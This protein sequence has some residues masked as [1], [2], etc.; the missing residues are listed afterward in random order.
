MAR[1]RAK[2]VEMKLRRRYLTFSLR[3]LFVVTTA[4]A[5]WLG[6]IVNRAREQREAVKAIEALGGSASYDWQY[7][8]LDQADPFGLDGPFIPPGPVWLRRLVGDDFFQDAVGVSFSGETDALKSIAHLKR[9]RKLKTVIV[10]P[11]AS[12]VTTDEIKAALPN[13]E[14]NVILF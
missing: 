7:A 6:V 4:L 1:F 11:F 9:L 2:A 8:Q 3:T 5:V 13:C 12:N 10:N 14:V